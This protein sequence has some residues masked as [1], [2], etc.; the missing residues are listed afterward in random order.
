MAPRV[1]VQ[2]AMA[3]LAAVCE[4]Q[5]AIR[6]QAGELS[7]ALAGLGADVVEL[8]TIRIELPDDKE[9]FVEGVAHAHEYDWLVFTS[10][11][12]VNAFFEKRSPQYQGK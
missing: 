5:E 8:P 3:W 1:T 11:N 4:A 6:E 12:G 9:G 10:V 2:V 7:R